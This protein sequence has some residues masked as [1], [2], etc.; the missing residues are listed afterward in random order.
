[1]VLDHVHEGSSFESSGEVRHHLFGKV[2][3][4]VDSRV[5]GIIFPDT[6]ILSG[7]ILCPALANQ[8]LTSCNSLSMRLFQSESF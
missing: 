2:D 1:M 5:E 3:R 6:D 8:N 7:A 4:S